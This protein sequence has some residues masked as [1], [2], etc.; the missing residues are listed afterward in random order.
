MTLHVG[1]QVLVIPSSLFMDAP[2]KITIRGIAHRS[3]V[4]CMDH[5]SP[6]HHA[7]VA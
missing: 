6:Q 2:L 3:L 4:I 5:V 7:V 1:D